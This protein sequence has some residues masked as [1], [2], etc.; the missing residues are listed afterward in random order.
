M[1]C[2]QTSFKLVICCCFYLRSRRGL[3][4]VATGKLATKMAP[5]RAFLRGAPSCLVCF[6]IEHF[7]GCAN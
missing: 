2:K 5:C 1:M 3:I 7:R 6:G 4:I